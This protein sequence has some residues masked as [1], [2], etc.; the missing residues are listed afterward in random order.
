VKQ[1]HRM[2]SGISAH[3]HMTFKEIRGQLVTTVSSIITDAQV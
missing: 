2:S 1:S 3:P